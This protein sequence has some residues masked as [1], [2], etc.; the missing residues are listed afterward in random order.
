MP[1]AGCGGGAGSGGASLGEARDF[2]AYRIYYAGEEVAEFPLEHISEG[3]SFSYGDCDQPSGL[4][5]EGG[6]AP[7]LQIQNF[8]ICSRPP[9]ALT[10]PFDTFAFRGTRAHWRRG[11]GFEI[12]A[13]D[14]TVV[15][16]GNRGPDVKA[17][18]RQLRE[19]HQ[20][21]APV[22]LPPPPPGAMRGGLDCPQRSR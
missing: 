5:A 3:W 11:T 1:L 20:A 8:A 13:G 6:C 22:R 15:I 7:P 16:F 2:A 9:G 18:A 19:V 17:A 4:F 10:G 14:T 12:F 21:A